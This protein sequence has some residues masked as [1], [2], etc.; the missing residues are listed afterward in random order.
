MDTFQNT[1]TMDNPYMNLSGMSP[2]ELEF[3]QRATVGLNEN[4]Q[5]QFF[6]VY[7][8]KRKIPQDVLI[9]CVIAVF[10]PGLQRFVLGQTGMAVLYFFTGGLFF[11]MTIMDLINHKKLA[12][13]FNKKMAYESFQMVEMT[14]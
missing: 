11:V 4:Q 3:L 6:M 9:F 2:E 8:S 10:I 5:K 7:T 12:L 14:S 13:E 1:Y